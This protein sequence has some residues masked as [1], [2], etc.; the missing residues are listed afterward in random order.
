MKPQTVIIP[1]YS[2]L[3]QPS[4][5]N[6]P[7][8]ILLQAIGYELEKQAMNHGG[9]EHDLLHTPDEWRHFVVNRYHWLLDSIAHVE[10]Q[11]GG[12]L[13]TESQ[14]DVLLEIIGLSL[15]FVDVIEELKRQLAEKE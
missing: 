11:T 6:I 3:I 12:A 13:L 10:D 1:K 9:M 8:E 5:E 7:Y 14:L 15:N 2:D 4:D